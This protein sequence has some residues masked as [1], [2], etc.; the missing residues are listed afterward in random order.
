MPYAEPRAVRNPDDCFFYYAMDLPNRGTVKAESYWDLRGQF[1][2]Y[3][4]GVDLRGKRFLEIRAASGFVSFEAG[5]RGADVVSFDLERADQRQFIPGKGM[6]LDATGREI[7]RLKN[8]YWLAHGANRSRARAFYGDVYDMPDELG[9]FD[10]VFFGQI[11]VH[12]RDPLRAI[13]QGA[14]LCRDTLV[15]TE[16]MPRAWHPTMRLIAGPGTG[17]YD[18]WWLIS[19]T[20]YRQWLAVLGFRVERLTGASYNFVMPQRTRK[21]RLRTIIARRIAA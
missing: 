8:A 10:V 21:F 5:K 13:E 20:L 3:S 17:S 4:G 14:R 16:G 7:D 12:L 6:D 11:L 19:P 2:D 1:E 15:I 9:R 18:G